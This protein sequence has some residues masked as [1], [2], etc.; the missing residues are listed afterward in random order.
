[1]AAAP[2]AP[3]AECTDT[4]RNGG[5]TERLL[6]ASPAELDICFRASHWHIDR[7]RI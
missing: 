3:L 2:Q 1:V 5:R 6:A 7:Y 4:L